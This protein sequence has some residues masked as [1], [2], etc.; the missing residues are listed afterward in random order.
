MARRRSQDPAG[1]GVSE[2]EMERSELGHCRERVCES[3]IERT[4]GR[5]GR[6]NGDGESAHEMGQ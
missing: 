6:I 5:E 2:G 3:A 1:I 4:K